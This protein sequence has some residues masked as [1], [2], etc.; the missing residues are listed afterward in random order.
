[1]FQL[2]DR[3]STLDG[4]RGT[5]KYVG[6]IDTWGPDVE[7][8]GIEWDNPKR[9]KNSGTIDGKT[10]F[11]TNI[12]GAGS[13]LK[14]SNKKLL[15]KNVSFIDALLCQYVD[16]SIFNEDIA[17]GNKK[18]ESYGFE[19]L[20]KLQ[21]NLSNLLSISLDKK[22]I[23]SSCI[24]HSH[25]QDIFNNLKKL[26]HLDLSFNLFKDFIA[27]SDIV[28]QI[29]SLESLN[30]NGNRIIG[31]N[32][33]AVKF[34]HQNLKI[35]KLASTYIDIDII[36]Q[37]LDGLPNL[38]ELILAGNNYTDNDL[39]SL[40]VLGSRVKCLDLSY[41]SL[42]VVPKCI[43]SITSLNLSNNYILTF[44]SFVDNDLSILDIRFNTI[45]LWETI[46]GLQHTFQNLELLRIN[47]NPL[48]E[49]LSI[50]EMTLNLIGR[51]EFKSDGNKSKLEKL[52]GSVILNTEVINGELY[53]IS[54][55]KKGE[56]TYDTTS[57]RWEQLMQKYNF[58]PIVE[59]IPKKSNLSL[60]K[61]SL[62][63]ISGSKKMHKVFLKDT[64]VLRLKGS[65]SKELN[66]SIFRFKVY[67]FINEFDELNHRE[68]QFLDNDMATLDLFGIV[69]GQTLY[70]V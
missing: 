44:P 28:S 32:P 61:L 45:D 5:V 1:M 38:R 13:F 51:L 64:T 17:F 50:D 54:K 52:N 10:Y 23:N 12:K 37:V 36:I 68:K 42:T 8:L 9:G 27:I 26:E 20:N 3:I 7:A 55:V 21:A 6:P 25:F 16:G 58:N 29:P 46:D 40:E 30:L 2:Y 35:I 4:D 69:T 31:L 56:Y 47:G 34:Q 49:R 11:A 66:E 53:F 57:Q 14:S 67:Y 60:K 65:I 43:S 33:S 22:Y 18:V 63:I 41:N 39:E 62:T 70:V 19:K 48:F 59:S 15:R 24:S